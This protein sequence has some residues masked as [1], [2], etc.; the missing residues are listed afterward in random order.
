MLLGAI[1]DHYD[2]DD[3]ALSYE[4]IKKQL[5]ETLKGGWIYLAP[6]SSN[7]L[8]KGWWESVAEGKFE[9]GVAVNIQPLA[10]SIDAWIKWLSSD[11]YVTD[12]EQKQLRLQ[13]FLVTLDMATKAGFGFSSRTLTRM[14]NGFKGLKDDGY[15]LEHI[16]NILSTPRQTTSWFVGRPRKDEK[17]NMK[18]YVERVSGMQKV[19]KGLGKGEDISKIRKQYIDRMDELM[20]YGTD[21]DYDAF[22]ELE[23]WTKHKDARLP[24][25][26][27][28]TIREGKS[29]PIAEEAWRQMQMH[30]QN[31]RANS[32]NNTLQYYNN[33]DEE[34][35]KDRKKFYEKQLDALEAFKK[36]SETPQEELIPVVSEITYQQ[37]YDDYLENNINKWGYK[38]RTESDIERRS[39]KAAREIASDMEE[40]ITDYNARL[41]EQNK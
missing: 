8:S 14:Y 7:I 23:K 15:E 37:T 9:R 22:K 4:Y 13:A 30:E 10:D 3:E 29:A 26:S 11:E 12:E 16:Y 5:L 38:K 31:A 40:Y 28:G 35:A 2:E 36:I 6:G 17:E 19:V 33:W 20:F 24:L 34:G 18:K 27:D 21:F 25:K 32:F 1:S 41:N 39:K